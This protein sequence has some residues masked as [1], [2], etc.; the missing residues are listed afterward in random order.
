MSTSS[1]VFIRHVAFHKHVE[2]PYD[3]HYPM[4]KHTNK[5]FTVNMNGCKDTVSIDLL[6]PT[7]LDAEN[8]IHPTSIAES[9]TAPP[10]CQV[11]NSGQ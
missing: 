5:H 11:T 9:E 7:H 2:T 1:H 3:G 4:V 8:V 6:K 10:T